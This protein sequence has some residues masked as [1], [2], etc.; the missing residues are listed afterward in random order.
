MS[1]MKSIRNETQTL[2]AVPK[3]VIR[4]LQIFV[5][6]TFIMLLGL[7]VY[8]GYLGTRTDPQ[9]QALLDRIGTLVKRNEQLAEK[10]RES[11]LAQHCSIAMLD[12]IED[13]EV[14]DDEAKLIRRA[15]RH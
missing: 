7:L 2:V 1:G 3:T 4:T 11:A 15:C 13:K 5:A 10:H 8:A 9:E 12:S 6:A 14:S